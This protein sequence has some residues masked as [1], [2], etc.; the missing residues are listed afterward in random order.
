M[1]EWLKNICLSPFK[2]GLNKINF[3][4]VNAISMIFN[5]YGKR[6]FKMEDDKIIKENE[7]KEERDIFYLY[8]LHLKQIEQDAGLNLIKIESGVINDLVISVPW[9]AILS[10]PTLITISNIELIMSFTQ[11]TNS[12]YLCSLE[13]TNS[14]FL[15]SKNNIKEN[16]D[17]MNAYHEINSLLLQYFNKINLQIE[18]I[19]IVLLDHFKITIDNMTYSNDVVSIDRILLQSLAEEK[20]KIISLEKIVYNKLTFD[21]SIGEIFIDPCFVEYLPEYYTDDSKS[22]LIINVTV[23]VLRMENM[24]VKNLE[25]R[26][27][28]NEIT[29]KQILYASV[30]NILLF[31]ENIESDNNNLIVF[32][33]INNICT[34]GKPINIKFSDITDVIQWIKQI[35]KIIDCITKKIIVISLDDSQIKQPLLCIQNITANIVYGDDIFGVRL[36][37]IH[38]GEKNKLLGVKIVY[39][40]TNA[41]IDEIVFNEENGVTMI[42]T[43]VKSKEFH[44]FSV[45]VT[46]S[47]Q[48]SGLNIYF[49]KTDAINLTE[50]INFVT[51]M[52]DKFTLKKKESVQKSICEIRQEEKKKSYLVSLHISNSKIFVKYEETNFDIIIKKSNICIT[53]KEASDIMAD[54]LMNGYLVA[55]LQSKY[56]F[57]DSINVDVL[58]FFIDPEIFDQLNYLCGTLTP[59]PIQYEP[60][61][62][63]TP[64]G[65]KQLH[66]AL[67]RSMISGTVDEL[68][69][70]LNETTKTIIETCQ[71]PKSNG[72][73]FN[74]KIF[75][76]KIFNGKIFNDKIFNAPQINI[77]ATSFANLRMVLIDDYIEEKEPEGLQLKMIIKSFH[78]YF[79][80][81]LV[82]YNEQVKS[83]SAFLCAIL[84][85]IEFKK[86]KEKYKEPNKPLI[87]IFESSKLLKPNT[88]DKYSL[89][90]KTGGII[91]TRCNNP[92]WKY[93]T[94]FSRDSMLDATIIM[95]GDALRI[96][97]NLASI[98]AN[99]RE[100]TLLR[101][102]AFFSNSHHAPKNNSLSYIEYFNINGIDIIL[103]YYPLI[104]EQIG[105][106]PAVF[107]LKDFKLC[108]SPQM[109]SHT[110][111]FDK[112]MNIIGNKWKDDINPDNIIQFIPNIK[113]IQPYAVPVIN[114]FQLT[115]RYFRH[116]H[117]KRKIRAITKNINKG[118]DMLS[119]F[120]KNGV[121]QVWE[122]FN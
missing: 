53:T 18:T 52:I 39:E 94:K 99:I 104:L 107:T 119:A 31:K 71:N 32:D 47:K 76:G 54:I 29:I 89:L 100:E 92:E 93:F 27:A 90:I 57:S 69:K 37:R 75:N 40:D 112:L 72:K 15:T 43:D 84:K 61:V 48:D 109:I 82:L 2:Y 122:Y 46:I 85:D 6:L 105:M 16:Q 60:V 33:A 118:A 35:N 120:I 97:I 44:I 11:N 68:E 110:E 26:I 45:S 102:L 23:D 114:F 106:G 115:T 108:L 13:N 30:E 87:S 12:I 49:D 78:C 73:I 116:S 74:G 91:D 4:A 42:N 95:H 21:L 3:V 59:E 98:T 88:M 96:S 111:G 58:Q 63:I 7:C 38:I 64:E 51:A 5:L 83:E 117:N 8:P 77:L 81:K 20:N 22:D 14:Y 36:N 113:I 70:S 65:L 25:F 67:A 101:L 103:N 41:I 19:E 34:F 24:C 50:I 1:A 79:F 55:R 121:D 10:E 28:P 80:N 86:I 62:E 56:I 9:Q 66:D 17:L